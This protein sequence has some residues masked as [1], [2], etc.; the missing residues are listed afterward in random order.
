[1]QKAGFTTDKTRK[2]YNRMAFLYD[3]MEA[4]IERLRFASPAK[5]L[6][7]IRMM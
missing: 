6:R 2:R 5:I 4:P 1:M 7:I 3:F